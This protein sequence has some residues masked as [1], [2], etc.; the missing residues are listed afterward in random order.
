[1][2][3]SMQFWITYGVLIVCV[4]AL[5]LMFLSAVVTVE[6]KLWLKRRKDKKKNNEPS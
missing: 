3:E 4:A 5:F 6:Y 2:N 1:M